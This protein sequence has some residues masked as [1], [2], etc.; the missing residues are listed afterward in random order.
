MLFSGFEV[1]KGRASGPCWAGIDSSASGSSL[2]CGEQGAGR[3]CLRPVSRLAGFFWQLSAALCGSV[4]I[5]LFT[6]L[7]VPA[8]CNCFFFLLLISSMYSCSAS[9]AES[10]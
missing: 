6:H 3:G 7:L 9:A 5:R 4:N 1:K 2:E 8:V 10:G